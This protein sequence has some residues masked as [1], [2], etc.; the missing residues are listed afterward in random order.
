[1]G[2]ISGLMFLVGAIMV[3]VGKNR[4]NDDLF[5][6]TYSFGGRGSDDPEINR[7]MFMIMGIALIVGAVVVWV[8]LLINGGEPEPLY[9][10]SSY[11]E[12]NGSSQ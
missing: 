1:M 10:Y 9:D 12:R 7:I 2:P 6:T 4:N 3:V 8:F 11:L 5:D